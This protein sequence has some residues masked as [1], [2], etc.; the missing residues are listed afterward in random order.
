M[1]AIGSLIFVAPAHTVPPSVLTPIQSPFPPR[2]CP[3]PNPHPRLMSPKQALALAPICAFKAGMTHVCL[4]DRVGAA[5]Q[6]VRPLHLAH[7]LVPARIQELEHIGG[8]LHLCLLHPH[9]RTPRMLPSFLPSF[10]APTL[11][12]TLIFTLTASVTPCARPF[13]LGRRT[14]MS[15]SFFTLAMSKRC[16][17]CV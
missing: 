3:Q 9:A 7:G 13:R 10:L 15:P 1:V 12:P 6:Q 2:V 16:G 5:L 11:R 8:V 14:D 17:G 4:C